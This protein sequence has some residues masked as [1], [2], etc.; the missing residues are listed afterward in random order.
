MK[1]NVKSYLKKLYEKGL[2]KEYIINYLVNKH[3]ISTNFDELSQRIILLEITKEEISNSKTMNKDDIDTYYFGFV[4]VVVVSGMLFYEIPIIIGIN[5]V[6]YGVSIP[7][8]KFFFK[9]KKERNIKEE[10]EMLNVIKEYLKS[11]EF[12]NEIVFTKL[13]K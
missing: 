2:L 6:V 8:I 12:N 5:L 1:Y 4:V 11:K 7:V 3:K 13:K 9:I 10:I